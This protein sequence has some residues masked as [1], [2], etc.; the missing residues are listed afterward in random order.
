ML[1]DEIFIDLDDINGIEDVIKVRPSNSN[2]EIAI[3]E[4]SN[5]NINIKNFNYTP[6]YKDINTEYLDFITSPNYLMQKF[7]YGKK[8]KDINYSIPMNNKILIYKI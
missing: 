4:I 5:P 1:K 7:L 2:P 8:T 3:R 6:E